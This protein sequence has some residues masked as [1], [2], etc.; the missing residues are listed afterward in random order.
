MSVNWGAVFVG[1]ISGLGGGA[2]LALP[3][4]ATGIGGEGICHTGLGDQALGRRS[5]G[6][7]GVHA[8]ERDLVPEPL[9]D[10]LEIWHLCGTR[11]AP[12]RPEVE[13]DRGAPEL[14]E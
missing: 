3:L 9:M 2:L 10:D 7:L 14:F 5:I 8:E 12:T 6:V 11:G 4:L 1:A 13:H